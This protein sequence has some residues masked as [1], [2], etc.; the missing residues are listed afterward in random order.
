MI[1]ALRQAIRDWYNGE[2][3]VPDNPPDSPIFRVMGHYKRHWSS[4]FVHAVA[5][6]YRKEWK[7]IL[8]FLVALCGVIIAAAK[9]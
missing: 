7:W 4:R 3:I 8:P 2:F 6:F 9:I 5:G 1:V